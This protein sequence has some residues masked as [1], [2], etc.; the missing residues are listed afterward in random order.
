[1]KKNEFR[2][3][4]VP[5]GSVLLMGD[6]TVFS[7]EGGAL[8][9]SQFNVRPGAVLRGP[10]EGSP[11]DLARDG[12]RRSWARRRSARTCRPKRVTCD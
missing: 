3:S 1:M 7:V 5:P 10:G 9:G 8:H 2:I 6:V 4:E 11:Q 12:R